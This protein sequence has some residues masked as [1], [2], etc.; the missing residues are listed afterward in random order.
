MTIAELLQYQNQRAQY[1]SLL[2]QKIPSVT[3]PVPLKTLEHLYD[4]IP[5]PMQTIITQTENIRLR[6]GALRYITKETLT[7]EKYHPQTIWV[8]GRAYPIRIFNHSASN[9][10]TI[11]NWVQRYRVHLPNENQMALDIYFGQGN[12]LPPKGKFVGTHL[13]HGSTRF[14]ESLNQTIT[15]HNLLK[16]QALGQTGYYAIATRN[17]FEDRPLPSS[18]H[19]QR[20]ILGPNTK[21][22]LLRAACYLTKMASYHNW[23]VTLSVYASLLQTWLFSLTDTDNPHGF[24]GPGFHSHQINN[25]ANNTGESLDENREYL[26]FLE[27]HNEPTPHQSLLA[28]LNT[29]RPIGTNNNRLH[30][31]VTPNLL[32]PFHI[33]EQAVSLQSSQRLSQTA[34]HEAIKQT[35]KDLIKNRE[36]K[37]SR[38]R[39]KPVTSTAG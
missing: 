37:S 18:L 22:S 6:P 10:Q 28:N 11:L 36:E 14:L 20:F 15:E 16:L 21:Q 35:V 4:N 23:Q 39:P 26:Q 32:R 38:A 5:L 33:Y 2:R 17:F 13:L 24:H 1:A 27:G 9:D 29:P 19:F 12:L 3:N 8:A 30:L 7:N 25:L 31:V 34:H